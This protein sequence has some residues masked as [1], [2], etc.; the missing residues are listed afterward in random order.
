MVVGLTVAVV[1][2]SL[3][4]VAQLLYILRLRGV[5]GRGLGSDSGDFNMSGYRAQLLSST[6]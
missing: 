5:W 3:C 1:V 6:A 2:L 4:A